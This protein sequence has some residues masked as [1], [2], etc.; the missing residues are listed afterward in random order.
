MRR[1]ITE[2]NFIRT[3]GV[4]DVHALNDLAEDDV[5]AIQPGSLDSAD[6]ELGA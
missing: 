2:D 5:A 1:C 4:D 6:E 3:D